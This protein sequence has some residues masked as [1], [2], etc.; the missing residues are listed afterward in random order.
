MADNYGLAGMAS[1]W[2]WHVY[3]DSA[4]WH[5]WNCLTPPGLGFDSVGKPFMVSVSDCQSADVKHLEVA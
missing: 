2:P 4:I 1:V 5:Q 3:S